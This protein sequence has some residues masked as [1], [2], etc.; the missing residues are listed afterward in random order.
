MLKAFWRV[1]PSVL[2]S[3]FAICDALV[4]LRAIVFSSRSSLEVHA[5]R[6]LFLFAIKPPFQERPLVSLMGAKEKTREMIISVHRHVRQLFL[7]LSPILRRKQSASLQ[8]MIATLKQK[9]SLGD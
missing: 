9:V 6:F 1:A 4:F 5:R 3:F 2:L 8:T 7:V